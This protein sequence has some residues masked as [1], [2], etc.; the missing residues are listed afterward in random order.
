MCDFV[1]W[2]AYSW[3]VHLYFVLS[4]YFQSNQSVYAIEKNPYLIIIRFNV[5]L[6]NYN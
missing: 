6:S 1:T 4:N 2:N 3:A 5:R